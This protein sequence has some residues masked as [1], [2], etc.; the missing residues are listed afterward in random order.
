MYD[1][2]KRLI[3][4]T[5]LRLFR[6]Y[7]LRAVTMDDIAKDAG[8]SKK[9]LYTWFND[10]NA[11]VDALY[12][13]IISIVDHHLNKIQAEEKNVVIRYVRIIDLALSA[14]DFVT[15]K[16][17]QELKKYNPTTWKKLQYFTEK[18]LV[19]AIAGCIEEGST[20]QYFQ[21]IFNSNVMAMLC[22]S[23][24]DFL[25]EVQQKNIPALS[26]AETRQQLT[27]HLLNGIA[28]PAGKKQAEKYFSITQL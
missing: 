8:M 28:T 7:G 11:M 17:M 3:L 4:K 13:S 5:A 26:I 15:D 10:K 23:E 25:N 2:K 18:K 19:T 9:T 21:P 12:R 1:H 24:L 20:Q 27:R 6:L 14:G 22:L 16:V